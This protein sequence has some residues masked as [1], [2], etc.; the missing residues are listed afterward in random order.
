M[1]SMACESNIRSETVGEGDGKGSVSKIIECWFTD[2]K[3]VNKRESCKLK[4]GYDFAAPDIPYES[5][6]IFN[7]RGFRECLHIFSHLLYMGVARRF[8]PEFVVDDYSGL[9]VRR[10]DDSVRA[11]VA[12]MGKQYGP[13]I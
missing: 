1:N 6:H 13:F 5:R 12:G 4:Y 7:A 2:A 9:T 10:D 11:Q 3:L 8:R